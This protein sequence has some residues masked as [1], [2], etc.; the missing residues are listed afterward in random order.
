MSVRIPLTISTKVAQNTDVAKF[1]LNTKKV[2][3]LV[4][5]KNGLVQVAFQRS[6]DAPIEF[7]IVD[8]SFEDISQAILDGDYEVLAKEANELFG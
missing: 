1:I 3:G 7:V 2:R 6:P 5:F 8:E 4:E